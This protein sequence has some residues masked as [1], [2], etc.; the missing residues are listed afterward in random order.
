MKIQKGFFFYFGPPDQLGPV[1][2][3]SPSRP[4]PISFF[5][6]KPPLP[7]SCCF[8]GGLA[9]LRCPDVAHL[10][11]KLNRSCL[12]PSPPET[13]DHPAPA[14]TTIKASLS[15]PPRLPRS[16]PLLRCYKRVLTPL[17]NLASPPTPSLTLPYSSACASLPPEPPPSLMLSYRLT[18]FCAKVNALADPACLPPPPRPAPVTVGEPKCPFVQPRRTLSPSPPCTDGTLG[19]RV[20]RPDPRLFQYQNKS[21]NLR[22]CQFCI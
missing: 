1:A 4:T 20:H 6:Q 15:L 11:V 8:I 9:P 14:M 22:K 21:K 3:C 17:T 16:R 13:S 2:Q 18:T 5:H 19:P 10:S 12:P 7:P